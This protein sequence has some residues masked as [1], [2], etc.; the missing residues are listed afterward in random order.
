MYK[1]FTLAALASTL[2]VPAFAVNMELY[3]PSASV[4]TEF[5]SFVQQ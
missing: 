4:E 2:V 1:V 5:H 3:E